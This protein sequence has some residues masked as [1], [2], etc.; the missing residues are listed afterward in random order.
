MRDSPIA[1]LEAQALEHL[2]NALQKGPAVFTSSFGSEDMVLGEIIQ[3]ANLPIRIVTLDTGR[4]HNETYE[5]IAE[6]RTRWKQPIQVF[7]PN[8]AEVEQFVSVYGIN[9]FK[10]AR[11]TRLSCC[12]IRKVAPLKRAL[13]GAHVWVTGLRR[14]QSLN[15]AEL[16]ITSFDDEHQL[17]KLNPLAQWRDTDVW[18]YL[19]HYGVPYNALHDRGYP[20]I[21][22][23]PCTRAIQ[24]EEH[25]RAGRW[26]WESDGAQECGLH[27]KSTGVNHDSQ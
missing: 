11:S 21:G 26:W 24:P 12:A 13:Q 5:L 17:V 27:L 19:H 10:E 23:A 18:Q 22:C 1:G 9:G 15:R 25:P 20:S 7:F 6:A 8:R 16:P 3:R 2:S 4:L 14:D